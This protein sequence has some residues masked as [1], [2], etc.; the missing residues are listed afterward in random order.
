MDR[1]KINIFKFGTMLTL[2]L[3]L[4][5]P[6][7]FGLLPALSTSRTDLATALKEGSAGAGV[8]RSS[9]RLRRSLIVAEITLAMVLVTGASLML[10]SLLDHKLVKVVGRAD[11]PGRPLQYGTTQHFL[12]RFGLGSLKDLPSV[13]EFRSLG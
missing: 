5:A 8:G 9:M 12:D 6:V 2:V 11:V 4:L 10:R 3:V 13:Q 1:S 7:L